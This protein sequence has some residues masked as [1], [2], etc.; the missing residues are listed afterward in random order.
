MHCTYTVLYP[1]LGERPVKK[2]ERNPGYPASISGAHRQALSISLPS[3]PIMILKPSGPRTKPSR[4]PVLS[5]PFGPTPRSNTVVSPSDTPRFNT[6]VP[7]LNTPKPSRG[8]PKIKLDFNLPAPFQNVGGQKPLTDDSTVPSTERTIQAQETYSPATN[9]PP[10]QL[11]SV[12][13]N[14]QLSGIRETIDKMSI[15]TSS[16]S[17]ATTTSTTTTTATSAT[18]TSSSS[19][20]SPS[21]SFDHPKEFSDEFLEELDRLGEGAGGA[22]YKVRDKRTGSIYAR[23]TITTREV[24]VKHV[25]REL[26]VISSAH[27]V[28][29]VQCYGAYIVPSASEVKIVMECCEGGSLEAIGKKIKEMGAVVGEKIAGRLAEGVSRFAFFSYFSL[30]PTDQHPCRFFKVLLISTQKK[31]FIVI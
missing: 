11:N 7:T 27:H 24:A 12:V 19:S 1:F 26:S 8:L 28:N 10:S 4:Q 3:L 18:T 17:S 9:L 23:K 30:Q 2:P 16:S 31:L 25:V 29:I 21:S 5:L 13:P 20:S 15:G 6:P 22:V 14:D